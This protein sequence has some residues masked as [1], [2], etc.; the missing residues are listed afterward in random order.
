MPNGNAFEVTYAVNVQA[1]QS[2]I[3][4]TRFLYAGTYEPK[5]YR[6]VRRSAGFKS[7]QTFGTRAAD[8]DVVRHEKTLFT[9][10]DELQ[11]EEERRA[12]ESKA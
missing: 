2:L 5:A 11:R 1:P 12:R 4:G 9:T 3:Y 8:S 6:I 7:I 10:P